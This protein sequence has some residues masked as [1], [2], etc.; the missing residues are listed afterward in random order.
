M[1]PISTKIKIALLQL[2]DENDPMGIHETDCFVRHCKVQPNQIIPFNVIVNSPDKNILENCDII[3][4]GG[5]GD[6]SI[7][8]NN[9]PW[10]NPLADLNQDGTVNILDV[11]L[12][13]NIILDN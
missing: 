4:L 12:L 6:Y 1:N 8:G 13:I 11:I 3:M 2:R 9:I 7:V 5:S 10:Y